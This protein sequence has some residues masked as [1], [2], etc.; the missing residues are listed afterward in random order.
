MGRAVNGLGLG[1]SD[2][3]HTPKS[4]FDALGCRFDLD[5]AAPVG[6]PLHVP[7]ESWYDHA[8]LER[9]WFGFVW[10]NPPFGGR[11]AL[12]PWM[13]KFFDHGN[14][15]ALT[16]DRTSAPWFHWS[17]PRAAAVLFARKTPFLL[18]D[19]SKAG[20]PAFGTVLWA[21]GDKAVAALK[22]AQASGFG[23]LATVH[24]DSAVA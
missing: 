1:K 14:G 3:W 23:L 16:P 4:V 15:I 21:V 7:C 11:N 6:G 18:A 10:M 5:V 9:L 2:E 17:W 13:S 12:F 20:S 8:S 24:H 22:T 19:G